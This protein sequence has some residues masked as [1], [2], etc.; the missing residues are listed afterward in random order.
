MTTE[1]DLSV[2]KHRYEYG[3][4][5]NG[6]IVF[7]LRTDSELVL[8]VLRRQGEDLVTRFQ[9]EYQENTYELRLVNDNYSVK[10]SRIGW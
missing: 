1:K 4:F 7:L 9:Q 6:K 2:G 8:D 3:V 5:E 10:R